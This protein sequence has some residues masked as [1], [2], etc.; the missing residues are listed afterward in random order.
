[1]ILSTFVK[2][3]VREEGITWYKAV[4]SVTLLSSMIYHQIVKVVI[5]MD[6]SSVG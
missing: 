5:F 3:G 2:K 1:M 4:G 6:Y